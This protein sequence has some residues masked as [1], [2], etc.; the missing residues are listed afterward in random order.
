MTPERWTP[1]A[2]GWAF[3]RPWTGPLPARAY[4]V[5]WYELRRLIAEGGARENH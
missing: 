1:K 4:L 2:D 5:P 3:V